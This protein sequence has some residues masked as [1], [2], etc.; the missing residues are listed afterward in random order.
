MIAH[1]ILRPFRFLCVMGLICLTVPVNATAEDELAELESS[2]RRGLIMFT[3]ATK[4]FEDDQ[5]EDGYYERLEAMRR[6]AGEVKR[7]ANFILKRKPGHSIELS[8]EMVSVEEAKAFAMQGLEKGNSILR[9]D[10]S[11]EVDMLQY[12]QPTDADYPRLVQLMVDGSI[13]DITAELERT[14]SPDVNFKGYTALMEASKRGRTDVVSLLVKEYGADPRFRSATATP[15]SMAAQ[16]GQ[17][18]TIRLL[19]KLGAD[20]NGRDTRTLATPLIEATM[21]GN[22]HVVL[23][24]L[25]EGAKP[26]AANWEGATSRAWARHEGYTRIDRILEPYIAGPLARVKLADALEGFDRFDSRN[27]AYLEDALLSF[28][29]DLYTLKSAGGDISC[30]TATDVAKRG[31]KLRGKLEIYG[32]KKFIADFAG[33]FDDLKEMWPKGCPKP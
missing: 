33:Y 15:M 16:N 27:I 14:H 29:T 22:A 28:S 3:L 26:E 6:A 30:D 8:G 31:E 24:L 2:L 17:V 9:Y 25:E 12:R 5:K 13:E 19:A 11:E 20:V 7:D 23:A 21:K 1:A 18:K 32:S 10:I 4:A